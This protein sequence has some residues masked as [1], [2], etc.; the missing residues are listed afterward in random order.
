MDQGGGKSVGLKK[1]LQLL[2]AVVALEEA[3]R[4]YRYEHRRVAGGGE[5]RLVPIVSGLKTGFVQKR[6]D[7]SVGKIIDVGD[8]IIMK[9]PHPFR[10]ATAVA[11][12]QVISVAVWITRRHSPANSTT[13]FFVL[14]IPRCVPHRP[15]SS[16]RRLAIAIQACC[17]TG[18]AVWAGNLADQIG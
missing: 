10:I 7:V 12:E 4:Q 6:V 9:C 2:L 16:T 11:H 18:G 3:W 17:W 15:T 13:N 14:P 5:E 8:Q 1:R